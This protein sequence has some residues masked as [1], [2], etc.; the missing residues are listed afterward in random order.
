MK[1][2]I[3]E[4]EVHSLDLCAAALELRGHEV[5]GTTNGED[6]LRIYQKS[7]TKGDKGLSFNRPFDAVILD[8]KMPKKDG[9]QA[10]KE[11]LSINPEQRIIFISAYV[12]ETLM[13]SVKELNQ[14]MELIQKPFEPDVLV[15][16]VEN[17]QSAGLMRSLRTL[18]SEIGGENTKPSEDQVQTLLEALQKIQKAK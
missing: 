9:K 18:A 3:A 2:L 14:V 5:I 13:D 4:D 10:A 17:V 8:Y 1:I 15:E 11:I 7:A 16:L 6:C 12:K